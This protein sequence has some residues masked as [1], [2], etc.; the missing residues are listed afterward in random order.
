MAA[1]HFVV[2]TSHQA[3]DAID[4]QLCTGYSTI[5]CSQCHGMYLCY[6][7]MVL[8][9]YCMLLALVLVQATRDGVTTFYRSLP[10]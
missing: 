4:S 6:G 2:A 7:F 1:C 5:H 3:W 8:C 9:Y 10:P